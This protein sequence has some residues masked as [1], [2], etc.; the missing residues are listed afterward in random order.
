MRRNALIVL[1]AALVPAAAA[2]PAAGQQPVP[3]AGQQPPDTVLTPQQRAM[4]RLRA[5]SGVAQ[6]D[7]AEVPADTVRAQQVRVGGRTPQPVAA[8]VTIQRDSVMIL[9]MGVQDYIVTEYAGDT[10]RFDTRTNRLELRGN[11]QVAREGSQLAADSLIV[12]DEGRAEACGYG[13]PVLHAVGMTNPLVSE[14]VCFN[15]D[16]QVAYA[17]NAQTTVAEGATWHVRGDVYYDGDDFYSH[18]AIFTDCDLPF[19]HH[20]YAFGARSVKVV[21]DNVLVAR[22]V[23]LSFADVPVFWMPFMVQSLSQGRRSGILMP[24]FGINDIA[25]SNARY[26]RRI[27]DVGVYWAINDYMGAELSMDWFADNWTAING[28]VDYT[29]PQRF[30]SGGLTYRHYMP[31]EGGRQFTVA[32]QNSWQVNERTSVGVMGNYTTSTQFVRQRTF[33]PRELNRSID[34]NVSLRRR[35]D[36]GSSSMG[37]S[38]KQQLSDNT[39]NWVLPSVNLSITPKTL[40]EALPGDERWYSN[41]NWQGLTTGVSINRTDVGEASIN[42]QAQSRR[43]LTSNASSGIALGPLSWTQNA[44]FNETAVYEREV[45]GDS[46]VV[47][48]GRA[49]QAGT[50]SS[51]LNFQQRLI[52]TST[53]TPSVQLGGRFH[54]SDR[55]EDVLLHSPTRI[56]FS[57]SLRGDIFG[58]WGGVGS[59]ERFRHRVSPTLSYSYSPSVRA[60][61]LQTVIFS[62][63]EASEQNRVSI[64]LSQTIEARIRSSVQDAGAGARLDPVATA[65]AD[66][67]PRRRERAETVSLLSINTDAVVYDF[68]RARRDGDGL[69]TTQISN[70]IQSDL[71]RGLQLSFTHDLF[72]TPVATT[73]LPPLAPGETDLLPSEPGRTFAPHLSRVTTSFSLNANSWLF[74]VLGLGRTGPPQLDGMPA[75]QEQDPSVGGPP[76]DRTRTEH[77]MIGTSRRTPVGQAAGQVGA[78][79]A[80]LNYT[81]YRP[82][83]PVVGDN[84][85]QMVIGRFAF[86]PT[87]NWGVRWS[88]GYSVNG[89]G[90]TDHVLTLTRSL[91]DWDANFDFVKAQNGNF[92]MQF[93]VHLRANPDIK[94]DYQQSDSP[95]VRRQQGQQF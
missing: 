81:L 19:P 89:N 78:W 80:D 39:I 8:P 72:R 12:Y 69:V 83:V 74:R 56:D 48:P 6:P 24:R 73:P 44:Q 68:V 16:R 76:M 54:R 33:D 14:I 50:W 86:Q 49:E 37:A 32:T 63:R 17:R 3:P 31:Q 38:R 61:S 21:R 85:N 40:F 55:T 15:V 53:L 52:G 18:D 75:L 91:H 92:S 22:N 9:L 59:F 1:V 67:A 84:E 29:W 94:L 27:E 45:P 35:F 77:G 51:S 66:T 42:R 46:V 65:A 58:F 7:T 43:N 47:L 13:Q 36:W 87:E 20:H 57:A 30:M 82:R 2:V 79:N 60:D 25:R 5:M 23:T 71:L 34:S 70:S 41:A 4:E 64:G 28:S 26:S 10:A 95:A 93:R 62:A 11:P 88:T 90:F